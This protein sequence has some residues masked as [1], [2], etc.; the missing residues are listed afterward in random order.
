MILN[1]IFLFINTYFYRSKFSGRKNRFNFSSKLYDSK[2]GDYN[3]FGP[4]VIINSTT[5]GNY[6][7][8]APNVVI[9]GMEHN[10]KNLSTSTSLF[11]Q[12]RK[13]ETVIEDDVWIGANCVIKSGI[14][15]GRGSIIGAHSLVLKDVPPFTII[16]GSPAIVLKQRFEDLHIQ[17]LHL[18]VDFTADP[19]SIHNQMK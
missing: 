10:Y 15:I 8:I 1:Y 9:G 3:Y 16:G 13:M 12:Q 6:C 18:K 5:I 17:E 14:V 4:N 7:S 2:I 11:P 19:I